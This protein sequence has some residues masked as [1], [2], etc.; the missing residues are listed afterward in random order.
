MNAFAISGFTAALLVLQGLPDLPLNS[1]SLWLWAV[2]AIVGGI[3]LQFIKCPAWLRAALYFLAGA[4]FGLSYGQWRAE[5]QLADELPPHWEGRDMT[6]EGHITHL[7]QRLA[8]TP[9]PAWRFD[10]Q[11]SDVLTPDASVPRQIRLVWYGDIPNQPVPEADNPDVDAESEISPAEQAIRAG[12]RWRLNVRLK[13]PHGNANPGGFDYEGWL[14]AHNIRATG[15]VRGPATAQ[16]PRY[17]GEQ[18]WRFSLWMEQLRGTLRHRMLATLPP[19]R[20]PQIGILIGLAIG[21]QGAISAEHWQLFNRTG[22]T[23][24]MVVSGSHITLLAAL[25]AWLAFRLWC[26]HS[27]LTLKMPAQRFSALAGWITAFFYCGLS[28]LGIP[29]LRT[30][31]MLTVVTLAL[32]QHQHIRPSQ[33]LAISLV[34]V[35]LLDPWAILSPGFWLSFATVAALLVTSNAQHAKHAQQP[36]SRLLKHLK[37]GWQ[38]QWA[39]TLATIPLLLLFFQE[40]PLVSPLANAMAIPLIGLVVTP[41]ALL[42]C[43]MLLLPDA[44]AQLAFWP[45][46]LADTLLSA[47]LEILPYLSHWPRWQTPNPPLWAIILAAAGVA[48]LLLPRGM[49][50]W[51]SLGIISLL[52][53]LFWPTQHPKENEFWA[54]IIDVGQGQSVLIRTA[55]H[56]LLYDSGPRYGSV[57][58]NP[59]SSPAT[60]AAQRVILP[61]LRA[62]GVRK[63]DLLMISHKDIDHSG[64]TAT[65]K[66]NIAIDAIMSPKIYPSDTPCQQG[67]HWEWSGIQFE[68]LHP[69]AE[70]LEKPPRNTNAVS[71]VLRVSSPTQRFLLTGDLPEKEELQLVKTG[72]NLRADILLSP[73][74]GSRSSSSNGFLS[75]VGANQVMISAGYRN[76]FGHPHPTVLERY[77]AHKLKVRRTDLDGAIQIRPNAVTGW[78]TERRR[79]WQD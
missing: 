21:D 33:T 27:Y 69:S 28:G 51:L 40:L 36:R 67:Q 20:Y 57:G 71:C 77:A 66:Q 46:A 38:S 75:A 55:D 76:R 14:F 26:R 39:A 10:F 1:A 70:V 72:A 50:E 74:H 53:A 7:P 15:Y 79:Y 44:L 11:V 52:P 73:H 5:I 47:L 60:D 63:L 43:L 30:L 24:L 13:R 64:G 35:L 2:S 65:L 41:L 6:V 37:E 54:N 17:L 4:T 68:I 56:A 19:E 31:G 42:G 32:F 25:V 49:P 8:D 58:T 18:P 29:A 12:Q 16:S 23:H 3:F 59:N 78:R 45:M 62:E 9:R 61:F 48:L 22:L 34:A